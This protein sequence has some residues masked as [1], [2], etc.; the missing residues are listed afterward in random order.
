MTLHINYAAL[1]ESNYWK[2]TDTRQFLLYTGPVFLRNVIS[3]NAC[4]HLLALSIFLTLLV[5]SYSKF[6]LYHIYFSYNLIKY[7]KIKSKYPYENTFVVY[8]IHHLLH[9]PHDY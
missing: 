5:Q 7:F 4:R 1:K 6:L 2:E 9:L 3:G 8:N